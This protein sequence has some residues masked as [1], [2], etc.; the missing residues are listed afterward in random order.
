MEGWLDGANEIL[1]ESLGCVLGNLL[2]VGLTLGSLDGA[3]EIDGLSEG[4]GDG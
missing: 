3:A 4:V 1:G 2:S